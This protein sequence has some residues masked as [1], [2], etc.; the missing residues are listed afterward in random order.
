MEGHFDRFGSIWVGSSQF[1]SVYGLFGPVWVGSWSVWVSLGKYNL[2]KKYNRLS[3]KA[4]KI[5]IGKRI[6]GKKIGSVHGRFVSAYV[7]AWSVC[8]SLCRFRSVWVGSWSV[9][10]DW[11]GS[12]SAWVS[13]GRYMVGLG[14]FGRFMVGLGRL[15]PR[16]VGS[17][18][19]QET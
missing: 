14:Q 4:T 8:V 5:N 11:V 2:P 6:N 9:W 13:L 18:S 10:V 12:W 7:G 1:G 15:G 17:W 16:W 19:V 3:D